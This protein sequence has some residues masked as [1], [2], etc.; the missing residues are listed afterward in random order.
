MVS[1]KK[2]RVPDLYA[3]WVGA[4]DEFTG[5]LVRDLRV[6]LL[7]APR[8]LGMRDYSVGNDGSA[9]AT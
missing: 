7:P 5:V 8:P 4:S 3:G 6:L 2:R 9:H 1:A